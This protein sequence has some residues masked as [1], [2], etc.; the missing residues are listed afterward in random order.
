MLS[1]KVK[2]DF[3]IMKIQG[4]T[5]RSLKKPLMRTGAYLRGL[6]KKSIGY[7]ENKHIHSKP[8]EPPRTH[9]K[10]GGKK[11]LKNSIW[12]AA[13]DSDVVIGPT[14]SGVGLVGKTHEFGGIEKRSTNRRT[15]KWKL[16]IGGYGPI[17]LDW[18][19]NATYAKLRT[20]AM[21]ARAELVASEIIARRQLAENAKE[22]K[23]LLEALS[24]NRKPRK[25]SKYPKRSFM[26]PALAIGKQKIPEFFRYFL[27]G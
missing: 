12:F 27:E 20:H 6:A 8:G 10:P 16:Y 18:S 19:G 4:K 25:V 26:G 14:R 5:K 11:G 7:R 17:R 13:D 3:D 1:T 24:R 21:V 9:V 2:I 23:K 15:P 22:Q